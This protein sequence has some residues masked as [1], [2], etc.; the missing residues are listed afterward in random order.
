MVM[1]FT[2]LVPENRKQLIEF[3]K[4]MKMA[5]KIFPQG[6][7]G[8][9]KAIMQLADQIIEELKKEQPDEPKIKSLAEKLQLMANPNL[10]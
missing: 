1:S 6:K 2:K 4:A 3:Y 7:A 10:S 9:Q 8:N 5:C